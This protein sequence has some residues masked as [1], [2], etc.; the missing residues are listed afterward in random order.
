V[1]FLKFTDSTV[2]LVSSTAVL[3]AATTTA[4]SNVLRM[5]ATN[6]LAASL[7]NDLA[8]KVS[9]GTFTSAGALGS[10]VQAARS[11]SSVATLAYQFFTGSTPGAGG[12]DYLVSPVGPNPNNLNSAYYQGLN[13]ENRYINFAVSLS[14]QTSFKTFYGPLTLADTVSKAYNTI[15]GSTPSAGKVDLLV[16]GLVPDGHGGTETRAQFFATY[17]QD[18]LNG[19]GTKAA[20]IG[21]LL[22]EAVILDIG[23]YA[24]SNDAYL[25]AIANGTATYGVD[26]IGQFDKPSYHYISG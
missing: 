16:N 14:G 7:V 15:F 6:S 12:M 9:D 25:T 2:R 21:W 18:N 3:D 26:L 4:I 24:L 23:D 22:G 13:L 11:T 1:E 19:L 10:I 8:Q 17:A 20:L 5:P